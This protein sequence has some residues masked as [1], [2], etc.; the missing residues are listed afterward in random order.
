[1]PPMRKLL[2]FIRHGNAEHNAALEQ[3]PLS[4]E[5]V[6][7]L[8]A[9]RFLDARLTARGEAEAR[10]VHRTFRALPTEQRPDLVVASPL[11]RAICT[12]RLAFPE[13]RVTLLE[14]LRFSGASA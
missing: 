9:T 2:A 1:M 13:R 14:H 6:L 8:Y 12:A 7:E 10:A 5:Q 3:C 4:R 11:S